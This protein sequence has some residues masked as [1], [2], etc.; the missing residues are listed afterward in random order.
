M[1]PVTTI[2]GLFVLAM[3][4]LVIYAKHKMDEQNADEIAKAIPAEC[5]HEVCEHM[6]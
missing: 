6:R 1:N 4:L 2:I 3:I 5:E